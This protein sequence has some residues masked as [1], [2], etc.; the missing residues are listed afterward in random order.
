MARVFDLSGFLVLPFWALMVLAPGA[1]WTRR[2]MAVPAV[3]LGPIFL[4]AA[5]VLPEIP[6]LLPALAQPRLDEIARILSTPLGATAAWAHFLA[7]DLF[8]GRWIY[9]DAQERGVSRWLVS[10]ILLL[11]LL[12]GPLGL[13]AYLVVRLTRAGAG[14]WL[15][16]AA[17]G[18]RALTVVA[19]IGV[20]LAVAGLALSALDARTV[21]GASTWLKPVKFGL[22][23]AI[24]SLTLARLRHATPEPSRTSRRAAAAVAGLLLLELVLITLQAARGVPSHFGAATSFD[25]AVFGAMGA[26]ITL[27]WVGMGVMGLETWR[28]SF[29][30]AAFGWGVRLGFALMLAGSLIGFVMTR[31]TPSQMEAL[32]AGERPALMGA[33]SVGVPDG[34][35]GLPVTRWSTEGGDLRV[36]HFLGLH[37]L[38][39]LPL[40]GI[41]LGRRFRPARAARL[42]WTAAW[43]Y[44]GLTAVALVQA[45]R[46]QPL[47]SP[48]TVTLSLVGVVAAVTAVGL[49][50]AVLVEITNAPRPVHAHR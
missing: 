7:F 19:G 15:R 4:Y 38:Q 14:G 26:A 50:L 34:G 30:D 49:T 17:E 47:S 25:V 22:S 48:D 12:F 18:S 8:V 41:G 28:R 10:P 39:I 33:H 2:L 31:P 11:T 21:L 32:A 16:R 27:A 5:L 20:L 45:L 40:V 6:N 24:T 37:A 23:V 3:V 36:A 46:G 9:L 44:A 35:P 1:S 13:G 29:P 42:V 43:T